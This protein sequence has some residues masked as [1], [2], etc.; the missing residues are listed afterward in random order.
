M[1]EAS[2]WAARRRLGWVV[3]AFDD[4]GERLGFMEFGPDDEAKARER[5]SE[6][7]EAVMSRRGR[8]TV[9]T[10]HRLDRV[11]VAATARIAPAG[12]DAR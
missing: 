6:L 9:V 7:A 10:M 2:G 8:A 12:E 4:D 11:R 3:E 1:S 5:Y